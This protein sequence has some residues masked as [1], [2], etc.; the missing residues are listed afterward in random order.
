MYQLTNQQKQRGCTAP[1]HLLAG[2]ALA[3]LQACTAPGVTTT[4]S[5]EAPTS[6]D[7]QQ[8]ATQPSKPTHPCLTEDYPA[9]AKAVRATG[10]TILRVSVAQSG[11]ASSAD[12]I[13]SAGETAEHKLLDQMALR[14]VL[15]PAFFKPTVN[16]F[17]R[18]MTFVWQLE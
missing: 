12:I 11:S 15:C 6:Q 3:L 13:Q 2:I 16:G 9:A 14:V 18:D 8:L 5:L 7:R 4:K 10:T 1:A 17:T